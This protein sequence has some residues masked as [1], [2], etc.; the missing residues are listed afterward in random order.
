MKKKATTGFS[1]IIRQLLR[2]IYSIRLAGSE[3]I[4]G[5]AAR[6]HNP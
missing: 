2:S 3:N 5:D 4:S 6:R 1:S